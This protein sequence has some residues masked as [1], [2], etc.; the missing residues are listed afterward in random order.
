MLISKTELDSKLSREPIP[1]ECLECKKTHY[2][3]KNLILRILNGSLKGTN[4]GCFCSHQCKHNNKIN[5]KIYNC[6]SCGK[7]IK[8]KPSE[9]RSENIFCG[10]SCSAKFNNVHRELQND[11]HVKIK[12]IEQKKIRLK[13]C[14][15]CKKEFKIRQQFQKY[16]SISCQCK[17]RKQKIYND[18]DSGIVKGHSS[19]TI[20]NYLINRRGCKCETCGITEWG[21]KPL[22]VIMD[23]INGNSD[24]WQLSNLRLIC[25]N[26]DTLTPTYKSKN[27]GFGRHF[28][29]ERYKNGQSY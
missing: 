12:I 3:P 20:R 8:K 15:F 24:D 18:I 17:E 26:C 23:H 4:K 2:R 21:G 29:R 19:N 16:C 25:S 14:Q 27:K 7:E 13:E 22:V 11:K 5:S 10:H 9:I 28:R 1:L 6:K